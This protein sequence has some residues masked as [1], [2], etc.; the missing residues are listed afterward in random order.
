MDE[1]ER[2]QIPASASAAAATAVR[3]EAQGREQDVWWR[4]KVLKRDRASRRCYLNGNN[5]RERISFSPQLTFRLT[6][7]RAHSHTLSLLFS[8]CFVCMIAYLPPDRQGW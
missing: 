4:K 7:R 5:K 2:S 6:C 3:R 1:R 8:S